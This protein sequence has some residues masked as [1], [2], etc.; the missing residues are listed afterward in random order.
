[1]I[2]D[3]SLDKKRRKEHRIKAGHVLKVTVFLL[4]VVYVL[5]R[6]FIMAEAGRS[7]WY[8][9]SGSFVATSWTFNVPHV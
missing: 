5:A 2:L 1:M 9:S 7:L 8:L 3:H 4:E 6:F